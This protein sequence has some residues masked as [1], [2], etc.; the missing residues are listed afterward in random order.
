MC[1]RLSTA[2]N[3]TAIGILEGGRIVERSSYETLMAAGD[4]FARLVAM[5][6]SG[7]LHKTVES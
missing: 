6:E 4:A 1:H 7:N 3:A 5:Q 2:R